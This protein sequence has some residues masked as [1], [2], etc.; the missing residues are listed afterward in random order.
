MPLVSVHPRAAVLPWLAA[1]L[2]AALALPPLARAEVPIVYI[3]C[4]RNDGRL[5]LS[6]EVV[7]GGVR[8]PRTRT[9]IG[10]DIY[11]TLP[12]VARFYSGFIHSCDLVHR[13]ETGVERVLYDCRSQATDDFVCSAMDPAVSFDGR[14]VAFT[15]FRGRAPVGGGGEFVAILLDPAAENPD[16]RFRLG[17]GG[18]SGSGEY[19]EAQLHLVDVAT[20][21]VTALPHTPGI[22]DT[23]PAFLSNGRLAFTSDRSGAFETLLSNRNTNLHVSQV[24]TMDIDGRNVERA[25]YHAL[26]GEQHP[27][28]VLDGRVVVSAW[29]AFGLLHRS[30]PE[31][32]FHLW[33]MSPDGANPYAIYGQH[34]GNFTPHDPGAYGQTH[35]AAHFIGQTS[36]GRLWVADYYRGANDGLGNI[37]GFPMTAPGQEG[38]GVSDGVQLGDVYRPREFATLAPWAHGFDSFATDMP[39]PPLT[40]RTYADPLPWAGKL[41]HPAGIPG[42]QLMVTW[43]VGP[44]STFARRHALHGASPPPLIEGSGGLADVNNIT[45]TGRDTPG[46]DAGIYR[47]TRIPSAHPNDLVEIVN[48]REFHEI[49]ARP[50]VPYREIY[51][52]D[53]PAVIPPA[54]ETGSGQAGLHPALPFGMLG[55]A[56]TLLRETR[57]FHGI[58]YSTDSAFSHQGTDTID[59]SDA[60]LCGIRI[61]LVQPNQAG[62]WGRLRGHGGERIAVLGEFP[63]RHYDG[64]GRAIQDSLGMEDTSFRVRFPANTPYLMQGIDCEGRAL[65]MDQSWQHVRAGELRTCGG[66]HVHSR[67]GLDFWTT[68]AGRRS[69]QFVSLGEGEVPLLR[70]GSGPDVVVERV[71]GYGVTFEFERDIWP[72]LQRRCVECHAGDAASAGLRLDIPGVGAESTYQRLVWDRGEGFV[73]EALR[74]GGEVRGPQWSRYVRYMSSRAS[75]LYWKAANQRTDHRTD[76]QYGPEDGPFWHD[77]D[78][79]ADHPT[80]VTPEELAILARWIDTGAGGG[81]GYLL[82]TTPPALTMLGEAESESLAAVHIGTVDA[83][84]GVDVASLEVCIVDGS[85]CGPDL[86]AEAHPHGVTRVEFAAPISDPD[87]EIRA[88]VLDRAG[89]RTVLQ[90]TVGHLLGVS[91]PP[92]PPSMPPRDAGGSSIAPDGGRAETS[93]LRGDCTCRVGGARD[94]WGAPLAAAILAILATFARAARRR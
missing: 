52:V 21:E 15:V 29:Q 69:D 45:W 33:G 42:N 39:D 50:A 51:G 79:G 37:V 24:H 61:L 89:N 9:L 54:A 44:C 5:V 94:A 70:G 75:L 49:M 92:I 40:I 90:R 17:G 1:V 23:G 93:A 11:D 32:L 18:R 27:L 46:C 12:E 7:I 62:E 71:P 80:S 88:K 73:P 84:S 48:T 6:G 78:F 66:C 10:L 14:T 36:D 31:N 91:A 82:D 64:S 20:G 4:P 56:S 60:E 13:D 30:T 58:S 35:L 63:V 57:P 55:G 67:E 34:L 87:A 41:S 68:E 83:P 8:Q 81:E 38:P 74:R 77:V 85:G 28:Q 25:S 53:R 22:F 19:T 86:A 59:Y 2:A 72:I 43:G 26:G 3:R 16:E 76:D 47:T 65:N